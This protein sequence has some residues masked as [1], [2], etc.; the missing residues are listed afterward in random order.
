MKGPVFSFPGD[1]A[2][3]PGK[4]QITDLHRVRAAAS[5]IYALKDGGERKGLPCDV[6]GTCH[7]SSLQSPCEKA[8]PHFTD[9]RV[10][11]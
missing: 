2:E 3:D 6:L 5:T 1:G 10:E 4:P 9:E 8:S 7:L 11:A